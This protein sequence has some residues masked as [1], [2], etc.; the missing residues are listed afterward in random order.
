MQLRGV[1][2][3]AERSGRPQLVLAVAA[4][5]EA[6]AQ[7]PGPASGQQ[8]PDGVTDDVAV[9]DLDAEALLA[10][11]KQVWFGLGAQHVAALDDDRVL[12]NPERLERE[13]D[14]RPA[15]GRRDAVDDAGRPQRGQQLD[16]AG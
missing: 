13:V 12:R 8:V 15:A 7:H 4:G 14:L 16:R 1:A 3:D 10:G 11:E 9:G 2:V 6:D 5:Q